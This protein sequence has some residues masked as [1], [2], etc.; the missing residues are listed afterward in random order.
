LPIACKASIT[1]GGIVE[2]HSYDEANRLTDAGV[3]YE[4]FGNTTKMP[5]VDAGGHEITKAEAEGQKAR[6]EES[7]GCATAMPRRGGM[8]RRWRRVR[9]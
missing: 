8:R 1:E 5:S 7:G 2:R 9:N 4:T 3:E 6:E